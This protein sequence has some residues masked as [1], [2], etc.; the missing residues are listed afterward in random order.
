MRNTEEQR[1]NKEICFSFSGKFH[2]YLLFFTILDNCNR[3]DCNSLL[4]GVCVCVYLENLQSY[5]KNYKY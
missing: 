1:I 5:F 3:F 2:Y 4:V